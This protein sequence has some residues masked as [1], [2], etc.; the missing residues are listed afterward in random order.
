[1]NIE[2]VYANKP[3]EATHFKNGK[4]YMFYIGSSC[5]LPKS[6]ESY[7]WADNCWKSLAGFKDFD[8]TFLEL[9]PAINFNNWFSK[10]SPNAI[11]Y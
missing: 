8:E 7:V 9:S 1:M 2:Q 3:N 6:Y 4:Y 5:V 11:C 10:P